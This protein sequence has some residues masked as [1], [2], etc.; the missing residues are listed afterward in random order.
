[1]REEHR[2]DKVI[3]LKIEMDTKNWVIDDNVELQK[4]S[5]VVEDESIV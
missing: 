4:V 1:M 2:E 5:N 3:V